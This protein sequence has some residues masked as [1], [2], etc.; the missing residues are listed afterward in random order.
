MNKINTTLP[1]KERNYLVYQVGCIECGV[2]SYPIEITETLEEA[3][4]I[5]KNHPNTWD[6]EGGAG[7]VT[8]IDLNTCETAGKPNQQI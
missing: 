2:S 5:Q 6:T 3:K 7:Y 1:N 8:I 4:Q